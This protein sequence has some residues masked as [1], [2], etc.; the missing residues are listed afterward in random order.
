MQK[1]I[2]PSK[3]SVQFYADHRI[4][5]RVFL[6]D[7]LGVKDLTGKTEERKFVLEAL[8][9][10]EWLASLTADQIRKI[11]EFLQRK[12][13]GKGEESWNLTW[14]E[15]LEIETQLKQMDIVKAT[16]GQFYKA[17]ATLFPR[18]SE[19]HSSK[20]VDL[21]CLIFVDPAVLSDQNLELLRKIGVREFSD[22]SVVDRI[23]DSEGKGEWKDWI[24]DQRLKAIS[25]IA[26]FIRK[27]DYCIEIEKRKFGNLVLPT[28]K[29]WAIASE[30]YIMTPD[31]TEVLPHANYIDL[32]KIE[33][34]VKEAERFLNFIDVVAFPR[35]V[36][37][38][39]KQWDTPQG[40]SKE[41]WLGYWSWLYEGK[42]LEYSTGAETVS[43]VYLDGFD[44]AVSYRDE[45]RILKYL[46]FLFEHWDDYYN[47][48]L[49]SSYHWFYYHSREK[50]VPSYFVYQLKAREW[51]P[52]SK[53]LKDV[54]DVFAPCKEIKRVCG[55]LLPYL[56]IS[57]E[58]LRK[59]D[60]FL[61]F[62]NVKTEVNLETLLSALDRARGAEVNDVLKTQLSRIYK[63]LANVCEDE[64]VDKDVHILDRKGNF[65]LSQ[66]LIWIDQPEGEEV[67]GEEL[68]VAWVP[69]NLSRLE[70]QTLFDALGVQRI[71][72]LM[73]REI[74]IGQE[75]AEDVHLTTTLRQKKDYLYSVLSHYKANKLEYFPR[76]IEKAIVL[77]TNYLKLHLTVLDKVYRVEVS[78]FCN[79][80]EGKIYVSSNADLMDIARELTKVFEAPS[81][82][83]FTIS[84]VISEQNTKSI[85]DQ[86]KKS[87][88]QSIHLPTPEKEFEL[89]PLVDKFKEVSES[90]TRPSTSIEG[91]AKKMPEPVIE[92][93]MDEEV[94][95]KE[96]EDAKKLLTGEKTRVLEI[97]DV[98]RDPKKIEKIVSK[99]RIVVRT[100]VD[101]STGKNWELSTLEGENVYVE[102]GIDP[103]KIETVKPFVKEF[104]RF[105][106]KIVEI[107]GG[108]PDTVNICIANLETDGDRRE[109]QLFFNALRNDKPFRWIAVVARELAY[110][111]FPKL[112]QA[113]INLMTD[114][115]AKALEKIDE[116]Y[117][118]IFSKKKT[119]H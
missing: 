80:E 104:R 37:L 42:H 65:Q 21:P 115:V 51:L 11:Y 113:H 29:G 98:W 103:V 55:N 94:L 61:Q 35:L 64:K 27:N 101:I 6:R 2:P 30:C 76:F 102:K 3:A 66:R 89:A 99:P 119:S 9:D 72:S 93:D 14:W 45:E 46:N 109:G 79:M 91:S 84:F 26:E 107:M 44:E 47:F 28:T 83:E 116:I 10:K 110:L 50:K 36:P 70:I 118:E 117:P 23:L 15:K 85:S 7:E 88:I 19:E 71:S 32:A 24:E 17:E 33:S 52:T 12:I 68:P 40:V 73:K 39:K 13:Y 34:F 106:C 58:Q 60:K 16:N 41:N 81:G 77:K 90:V 1:I 63:M 49:E 20:L 57:E 53:G 74:I 62:L 112:S 48:Y 86:F 25:Y 43:T 18:E 75:I 22:K 38:E 31:L 111:K 97:T 105:L 4:Q 69:D 67:F 95:T 56:K 59:G 92:T 5:G 54:S 87:C 114:L 100:T 96:M 8:Q 82:A 108:N 78:C